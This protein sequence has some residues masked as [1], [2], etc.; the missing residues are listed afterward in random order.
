M[1]LS[2]IVAGGVRNSHDNKVSGQLSSNSSN[3]NAR[4]GSDEEYANIA[5]R[6]VS[7]VMQRME[8]S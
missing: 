4:P 8:T 6:L 1:L 5:H 3:H 7:E 2:V